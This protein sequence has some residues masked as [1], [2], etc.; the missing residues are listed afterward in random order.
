MVELEQ[1]NSELETIR[2]EIISKLSSTKSTKSVELVDKGK[3][4]LE[5]VK[6]TLNPED[7]AK[8]LSIFKLYKEGQ[9]ER[10]AAFTKVHAL[11]GTHHRDL[12]ETFV[13]LIR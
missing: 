3:Q 7:F 6:E 10:E 12:Y 1:E 11:F 8:F 13:K 2:R 9:L 4:F 5:Q